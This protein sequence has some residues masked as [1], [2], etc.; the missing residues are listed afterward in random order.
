MRIVIYSDFAYREYQGRTYA[1]QPF[2][3]FL[4][5]LAEQVDHVTLIGRLDPTDEPWHFPLPQRVS[6]V[7]LPYYRRASDPLTVL[8]AAR[9]SALRF[10]RAL[11]HGDT[12][13]VFGPS[14]L[15]VVFALLALV[16]GRRVALGVRQDYIAYARNRHPGRRWLH[17]AAIVL[18][19]GFR[20]LARRCSVIAVGPAQSRRYADARRLL[21]LTVALIGQDDVL[22]GGERPATS[23]DSAFVV[24]SVGRL[25][26]EKNPL[27]LADILAELVSRDGRW[28]LTVCGEGPLDAALRGRLRELGVHQN[29]TLRGFVPIGPSL[30][31]VYRTSDL[32]LHTS[33]TEGA[34]Q[35]LFEAF[36]AGLPVVATDVGGVAATAEGAAVLIP[37]SDPAAAA[38]ALTRLAGDRELRLRLIGAGLRIAREHTRE[39]QS[40][41]VVDFLLDA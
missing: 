41:R 30:R 3:I 40:R 18:D 13:L 22:V 8:V 4:T 31:E 11:S 7:A 39:R 9:R 1:E 35:V 28:R 23:S 14:P 12:A 27:L 24:L 5:A 29:A 38:D 25:D 10:W 17:L 2:V 6:Y 26:H 21:P 36:A 16:R 15:A 33:R 19:A 34:P 32:F 20:L 37:P